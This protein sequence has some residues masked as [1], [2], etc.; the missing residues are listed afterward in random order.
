MA[1]DQEHIME[2]FKE[3]QYVAFSIEYHGRSLVFAVP[4]EN[5]DALVPLTGETRYAVQPQAPSEVLCVM[6][7]YGK[8]AP[9]ISLLDLFGVSAAPQKANVMVMVTYMGKVIGFPADSAHIV[10][11]RPQEM[12]PNESTGTSVFERDNEPYFTLDIPRLYEHLEKRCS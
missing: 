11:A 10:S 4:F 5:V 6:N 1:G 8:Q 9:I 3:N 2:E 7:P 12:I